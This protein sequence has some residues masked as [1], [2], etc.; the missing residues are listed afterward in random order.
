MGEGWQRAAG[1]GATGGRSVEGRGLRAARRHYVG[2]VWWAAG[3]A[4]AGS[5]L[6]AVRW[7]AG[8]MT[9]GTG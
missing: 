1:S 4:A 6:Y 9:V 7:A 8:G 3:D 2:G 5:A